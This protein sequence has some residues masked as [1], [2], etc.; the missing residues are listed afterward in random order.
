VKNAIVAAFNGLD[1]GSR[2]TIGST[3]Y[4]SRYYA[5]ILAVSQFPIEILYLYLGKV[6]SA[7]Y[8]SIE[9]WINEYPVISTSDVRVV[10]I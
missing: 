1:G 8:S 9:I 5:P 6:S 2:A 3:L 4:A 10:L 7:T